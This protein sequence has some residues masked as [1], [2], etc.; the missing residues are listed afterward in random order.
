MC[1]YD[2]ACCMH[3]SRGLVPWY[4]QVAVT[5]CT[6]MLEVSIEVEQCRPQECVHLLRPVR[7]EK[8]LCELESLQGNTY[9]ETFKSRPAGPI[10]VQLASYGLAPLRRL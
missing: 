3:I 2:I 9:R 5:L 6:I 4:S 10:I 8:Y 7:N 1:V